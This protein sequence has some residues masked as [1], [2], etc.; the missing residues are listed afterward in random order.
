M[1]KKKQEIQ[2]KSREERFKIVASRRVQEILNKMR[3]LRNCSNKSNYEY[4]DEQVGKIFKT[5][6]EEWKIVKTEFNK[7]Q[8]KH[9]EFKL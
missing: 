8:T 7:H 3:L 4:T 9:R 6:D 1:F 5:I 2:I